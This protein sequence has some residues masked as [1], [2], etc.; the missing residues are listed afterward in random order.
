VG[1]VKVS[2]AI[3]T[4]AIPLHGGGAGNGA[5]YLIMSDANAFSIDFLTNSYAINISNGSEV[6]IFNEGVGFAIDL[7]D[8]S[9]A[10]KN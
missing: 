4:P 6:L 10:V 3:A 9:Y 7:T 1:L 2:V 8:N 5:A